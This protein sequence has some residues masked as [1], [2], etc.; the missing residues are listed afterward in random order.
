[1][2]LPKGYTIRRLQ[3]SDYSKGVL[4]TLES[5]TTVGS[6]S[7][8]DFHKLVSHWNTVKD[9]SGKY[10]IYN[11]LVILDESEV[12]VATGMIF[13]EEKI[14]HGLGLVGHIEDISV[15]SSQQGK[16][17]GKFLIDELTRIGKEYGCYKII[18]DCDRKNVGFYEKCGYH[19][20]GVEMQIRFES[21]KL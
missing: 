19:E 9:I 6:I 21:N 14:I 13:I 2:S 17:L 7:E 10:N 16:K 5:L 12:I 4:K 18:L 3:P 11:P 15:L 20:A 8:P 1:M